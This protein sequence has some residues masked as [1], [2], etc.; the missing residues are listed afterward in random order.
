MQIKRFVLSAISV[1]SYVLFKDKEAVVIDVGLNPQALIRFLEEHELDLQGILITHGHFDHIGG[2]N[3]LQ[4]KFLA[5]V[6]IHEAE[7]AWLSNPEMNGSTHFPYFGEIR[8]S[9]EVCTLIGDSKLKVGNFIFDVIY[10]P[11]HSPG[12]VT[13]KIDEYLF[14]GDT[15]FKESIGRTDFAGGSHTQILHSIN[16]KLFRFEEDLIVYPGH[17]EESRLNHEKMFNPYLVDFNSL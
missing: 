2:I 8:I 3:D 17:G 16:D 9:T 14:T 12:G 1:N 7:A 15:L 13:Y 10:T 4:D 11:G 5:P 6:Y